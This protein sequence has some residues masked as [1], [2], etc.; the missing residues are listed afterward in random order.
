MTSGGGENDGNR[1]ITIRIKRNFVNRT[2]RVF[3]YE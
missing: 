2:D 3:K 1:T